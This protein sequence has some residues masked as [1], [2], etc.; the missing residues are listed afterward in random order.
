MEANC[1]CCLRLAL[2]PSESEHSAACGVFLWKQQQRPC[3]LSIFLSESYFS[4][5]VFVSVEQKRV[6]LTLGR[7]AAQCHPG[8]NETELTAHHDVA[9]DFKSICG[10]IRHVWPRLICFVALEILPPPLSTPDC[11][12]FE[13]SQSIQGRKM[14]KRCQSLFNLNGRAYTK[15]WLLLI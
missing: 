10:T 11:C 2:Q 12:V 3:G 7:S 13:N 5:L 8:R 1:V 4:E 9:L 6:R 15:T 14:P